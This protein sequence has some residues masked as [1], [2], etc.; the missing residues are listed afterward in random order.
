[1]AERSDPAP[2]YSFL[3]EIDGI[4]GAS[5]LEVAGLES[6]I[7]VVEYREGNEKSLTVRK[8]PGLAKFPNVTLKRGVTT[9]RALWDWHK[10]CATG[11]VQRRAV[12]IVLLDRAAKPV[13][14]W[15]LHAAW[16]AKYCGPVL[17]AAASEVAIET[18]ELAH[19]GIDVE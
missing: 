1:M 12:R 9:D 17:N 13:R 7:D 19:E 8:L 11:A 5:F 6:A 14:A 16:P 3:V 10:Q 2:Q 18:I 4:A 15:K